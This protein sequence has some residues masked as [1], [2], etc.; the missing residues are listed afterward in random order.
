MVRTVKNSLYTGISTDVERRF[1]QHCCGTGAK[2]LKGKGPLTLEFQYEVG[3]R[4]LATRLEY[5]L[6]QLSKVQKEKLV[7][8]PALIE[9][10][11]QSLQA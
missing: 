5:R 8:T 4:S 9:E 6:K 1:K 10:Y 7:L 11:L 3:N 2:A